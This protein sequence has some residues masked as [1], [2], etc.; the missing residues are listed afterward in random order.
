MT[1]QD[2]IPM[3]DVRKAIASLVSNNKDAHFE[4]MKVILDHCSRDFDY[5]GILIYCENGKL[6]IGWWVGPQLAKDLELKCSWSAK[7]IDYAF[8]NLFYVFRARY[9]KENPIKINRA[10][11]MINADGDFDVEYL[12]LKDSEPK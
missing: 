9:G 5:E 8:V 1:S 2:L 11:F 7:L 6:E 3:Y 4:S 10:Q 12:Y